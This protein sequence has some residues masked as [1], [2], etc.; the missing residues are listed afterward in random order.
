[1]GLC[2]EEALGD[3]APSCPPQSSQGWASGE[4]ERGREGST[5]TGD[6]GEADF[7]ENQEPF[8]LFSK[9]VPG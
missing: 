3:P 6:V 9:C 2:L 7:L 8:K 1:M 5:S 4:R